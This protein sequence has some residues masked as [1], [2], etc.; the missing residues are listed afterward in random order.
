MPTEYIKMF[1]HEKIATNNNIDISEKLMLLLK[2]AN[3]I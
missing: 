3:I 2:K 1:Y